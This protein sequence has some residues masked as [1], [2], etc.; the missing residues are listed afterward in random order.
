MV[1]RVT[2]LGLEMVFLGAPNAVYGGTTWTKHFGLLAEA[3]LPP[4]RVPPSLFDRDSAA[5]LKRRGLR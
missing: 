1:K 4:E 2:P 3:A 5:D